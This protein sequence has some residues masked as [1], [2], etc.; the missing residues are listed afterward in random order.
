MIFKRIKKVGW[1]FQELIEVMHWFGKNKKWWMT[2]LLL[3]LFVFLI[4]FVAVEGT[5]IAPFVYTLF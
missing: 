3:V 4:I 2:P 1:H 5:V